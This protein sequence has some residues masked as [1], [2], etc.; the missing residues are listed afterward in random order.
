VRTEA[1]RAALRRARERA[2]LTDGKPEPARIVAD[3][4]RVQPRWMK[5]YARAEGLKPST[6]DSYERILRLHLYPA[7][8]AV[9]L[10]AIGELQVQKVK[11]RLEGKADKTRACVLSLLAEM[12]GAAER[13]EEIARAPRIELPSYMTKEME[14]Y[15]FDRVGALVAG[16]RRAGPMQLAAILLGGEAGL[17]RGELVAFEQ[18]DVGRRA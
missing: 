14:F 7:L 1:A 12:L 11:L 9:R 16:A 4:R 3:L 8:G 6:L 18:G 13:W 5:D 2:L 17:R 10:D 15:D